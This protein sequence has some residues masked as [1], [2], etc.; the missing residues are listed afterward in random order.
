MKLCD[1]LATFLALAAVTSADA[2]LSESDT[3]D[4]LSKRPLEKAKCRSALPS[5]LCPS[6][7]A[8]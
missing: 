3:L 8:T 5:L 2:T 4:L 6:T 1:V 7:L